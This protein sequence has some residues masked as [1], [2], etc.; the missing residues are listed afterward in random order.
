MRFLLPFVLILALALPGAHA[1]EPVRY[2]QKG[3]WYL[4]WSGIPF[5]K[6]WVNVA[7][8]PEDY[9]L[10]ASY[11]SRG[12]VRLFNKTKSLVLSNGAANGSHMQ[13]LAYSYEDAIKKSHTSL[14]FDRAGEMVRRIVEPDDDPAHRP[15][16]TADAIKGAVTPGDILFAL[17]EGVSQAQAEGNTG[18]S[19]LFYEGKRLMQVNA[20]IAP[21]TE[22]YEIRGKSYSVLKL[23][24][25]RTLVSGFT[26]K[27][28]KR[29]KKGEPPLALYLDAETLFP[30]AF[31]I[32]V[33]FGT[34]HAEWT[35][36]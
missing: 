24:L 33:K 14:E 3:S 2:N 18:F 34:L 22:S 5:A 35:A 25:S 19:R 10:T 12:L 36:E 7:E 31:D 28:I 17:R 4:S 15:P 13:V 6:L 11:K 8:T 21:D 29:Y 9:R 32:E 20:F 27:E 30:L 23:T 16:V 26:N 1:Q